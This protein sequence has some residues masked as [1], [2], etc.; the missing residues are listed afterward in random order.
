[1][2][3]AVQSRELILMVKLMAEVKVVKR[4]SRRP[5]PLSDPISPRDPA[6]GSETPRPQWLKPA[7]GLGGYDAILIGAS[8]GGPLPIR[9]ILSAFRSRSPRPCSS[10][11]ISPQVLALA[12]WNGWPVPRGFPFISQL[13]ENVYTPDTFTSLPTKRTWA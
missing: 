7:Y 2:E 3:S 6:A 1:M 9:T 11:S 4:W 10:F 8:T 13:T 5:V 12:L